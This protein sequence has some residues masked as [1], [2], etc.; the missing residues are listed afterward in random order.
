MWDD[1]ARGPCLCGWAMC[2]DEDDDGTTFD[3]LAS[4]FVEVKRAKWDTGQVGLTFGII[5][6][7]RGSR[8][9]VTRVLKRILMFY[10]PIHHHPSF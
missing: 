7:N 2:N 5:C 1:N 8:H 6:L 9:G 4:A 3:K 10:S